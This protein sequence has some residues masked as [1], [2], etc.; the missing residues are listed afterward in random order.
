MISETSLLISPVF[1]S[2]CRSEQLSNK[3]LGH[4]LLI[5]S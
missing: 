3:E 1:G 2:N 5:N 4:I